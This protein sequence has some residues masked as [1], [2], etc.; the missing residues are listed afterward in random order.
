MDPRERLRAQLAGAGCSACG[1]GVPADGIAILA[2]RGD[3]AFVELRCPTCGSETMGV[4]VAGDSDV[5][6][7]PRLLD[8]PELEDVHPPEDRP[9]ERRPG[10]APQP[11]G[12]DDVLA[13]RELLA[14]WDGDLRSLLAGQGANPPD[15]DR[16]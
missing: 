10:P 1:A 7:S 14:G 12:L 5:T 15:P 16:T 9:H 6:G 8:A 3:V 4:V 11:V 13:V 2:D